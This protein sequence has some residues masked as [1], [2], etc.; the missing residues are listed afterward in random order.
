MNSRSPAVMD[1]CSNSWYI[2]EDQKRI[3]IRGPAPQLDVVLMTRDSYV[4]K[5]YIYIYI[6]IHVTTTII[7]KLL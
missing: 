2:F 3:E 4:G 6:Q 7:I 5:T 1:F